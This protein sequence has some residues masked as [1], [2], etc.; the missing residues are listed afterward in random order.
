MRAE[1]LNTIHHVIDRSSPIIIAGCC[2]AIVAAPTT[3]SVTITA[4]AIGILATHIMCADIRAMS[5]DT[6]I[7]EVNKK[8]YIN[9]LRGE[10]K[11]RHTAYLV[12]AFA[13]GILICIKLAELS[14][15]PKFAV[16]TPL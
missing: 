1:T 6:E 14:S 4:V 7:T 5:A 12:A 3:L 16:R 11:L 2:T 10:F 15:P 9:N 8:D 13:V